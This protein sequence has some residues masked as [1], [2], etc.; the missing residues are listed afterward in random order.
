MSQDQ[1][2]LTQNNNQIK[3]ALG[4]DQEGFQLKGLI[5]NHLQQKGYDVVDYGTYSTNDTS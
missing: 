5:L 3:I 2:T 1:S 4:S